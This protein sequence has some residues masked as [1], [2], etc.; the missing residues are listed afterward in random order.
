MDTLGSGVQDL[1]LSYLWYEE[2][3]DEEGCV[4]SALGTR[5][6]LQLT[7]NGSGVAMGA[8]PILWPSKTT[9]SSSR[10]TQLVLPLGLENDKIDYEWASLPSLTHLTLPISDS[11]QMGQTAVDV[12]DVKRS[13]P[14][15]HSL[16]LICASSV[17][18][19]MLQDDIVPLLARGIAIQCVS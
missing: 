10:I 7:V 15:L 19:S 5:E 1:E 2:I 14:G 17:N 8:H 11:T 18:I 9:K 3:F 12:L 4:W 13:A 6:P 16:T